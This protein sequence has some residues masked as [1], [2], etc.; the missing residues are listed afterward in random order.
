MISD[1]YFE[2]V[3]EDPM[4][5]KGRMVVPY[6][7]FVGRLASHFY[8]ELRDNQKILAMECE[9]CQLT[10]VPPR[11]TCPKCFAK[12]DQWKEVGPE[13][14][15]ESWTVTEYSLKIHPVKAPV[16]YGIVKL[17]GASTGIVHILGE[18][19]PE[20]LEIGQRVKAVFKEK[21]EGNILDIKYFRPC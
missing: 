4:V 1:N 8:T 13:G 20:R 5:M 21:R 9:K 7:Y 10:Y 11:N 19:D 6:K 14:I 17:D 3:S 12:L 2:V 15:L 18:V 16:I